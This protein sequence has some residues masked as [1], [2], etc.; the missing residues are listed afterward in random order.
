MS[1]GGPCDFAGTTY[2]LILKMGAVRWPQ[3]SSTPA[4]PSACTTRK[5]LDRH[6]RVRQLWCGFA[7]RQREY[8]QDYEGIDS[9]GKAFLKPADWGGSLTRLLMITRSSLLPGARSIASTPALRQAGL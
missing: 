1:I 7:D 6:R 8:P 2:E 4:A 9:K 3:M 5:I